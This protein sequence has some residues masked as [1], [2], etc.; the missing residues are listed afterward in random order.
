MAMQTVSH[1]R[2]PLQPSSSASSSSAAAAAAVASPSIPPRTSS[3][4]RYSTG[5]SVPAAGAPAPSN[6]T[7]GPST[8]HNAFTTQPPDAA[9]LL[10]RL[11]VS[12]PRVD[13]AR[14]QQREMG[15]TSVSSTGGSV[16][17]QSLATAGSPDAEA[18]AR[19]AGRAAADPHGYHAR[20]RET[21]FGQYVLGQTLGEGEFGKVK[22]GWR[23]ADAVQ[24]AIKLIR[25]ES[26]G[27]N[28]SRLPK[29]HREIMILKELSHPNIVRLHEMV[30][31]DRYIGIILE[32]ASGGELFDYILNHRYLKDGAARRLFAQLVSGVGY[33]HK[34]GIVHRDLKLENL[35]L[36]RNRNII[37]TDFGFA[38]T[39]DP[40]DDLSEEIEQNLGN[41][42]FVR[43]LRLDRPDAKGARRGDLMQ[44][45]CGSPCYAA[46]ELVVSDS[47]YT[48]RK[49]DVWSCGVILYAMLAGYL[50]FD[51]DPANPD[52]D[53]INLLYK[54]IV[55]TPLT[56]PEHITPHARDLLRRILVPDP[57]K[58]ADLFEVARHSWLAEY[59]HI[60]SH[61]T[62]GTTNVADIANTTVPAGEFV[63]LS[64]PL[65]QSSSDNPENPEPP[66]LTRSASVREPPKA[67]ATYS[68]ALGG[69][70][71]PG[72]SISPDD[73]SR[74]Q[75][76]AKRR[77]LQVEYVPPQSQTSRGTSQQ[78]QQNQ[79]QQQQQQQQ[80]Y[81]RK[82][83]ERDAYSN[84]PLP[85]EPAAAAAAAATPSQ[86]DAD[87]DRQRKSGDFARSISD[88]TGAF[89][90]TQ[91]QGAL[92]PLSRPVTGGSMASAAGANRFDNRVPP[93]RGSYGQPQ[94]PSSQQQQGPPQPMQ[95]PPPRPSTQQTSLE[96]RAAS[97]SPVPGPGK[98]HKRS[99]TVS[100]I[101]EKLFGRTSSLFGSGGST[102]AANS[103]SSSSS[104]PP[105]SA[106]TQAPSRSRPSKRYP[107]TSMKEPLY[108]SPGGVYPSG[109][110]APRASID[111][112]RSLSNPFHRKHD[113]DVSSPGGRPRRFSLLP[114]VLTRPFSSSHGHGSGNVSGS[115]SGGSGESIPVALATNPNASTNANVPAGADWRVGM[116]DSRP[117]LAGTTAE[118]G[119]PGPIEDS[120]RSS[121]FDPRLDGGG[122][123]R[124]P[125]PQQQQRVYHPHHLRTE[126]DFYYPNTHA[127]G[128]AANGVFSD[129][130]LL[131]SPTQATVPAT[132][133][134]D[135][136]TT[137]SA[138][139]MTL[140]PS[141]S[142]R[143]TG[144]VFRH[145]RRFDEAYEPELGT[146]VGA[147]AHGGSSGPA[148]R[149]M[150]FFRRRAKARVG[151]V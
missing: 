80:Q 54:Y 8:A 76:D 131:T 107:P 74:P 17:Q 99:T 123:L 2:D 68:P 13:I 71:H 84:K 82:D 5:A 86:A 70:T 75:R 145:N 1:P 55:S 124:Q 30:E 81:S 31:T 96:Y 27:S 64:G 79:H 139:A 111:S 37:I 97:S 38:N 23:R 151:D 66:L 147:A 14:E 94:Q 106:A 90:G 61:I 137:T 7:T 117:S 40:E 130:N 85:A 67:A 42:H 21:T 113:S 45:S 15:S 72:A 118:G 142:A 50:P 116:G 32:Y 134:P 140:P 12:D 88:L 26:L 52:G 87:A 16:T 143:P 110:A 104:K 92:P 112:R 114:P 83:K 127:T 53:N 10:S 69:L 121:L 120:D 135:P 95:Y 65:S 126:A 36:D 9:D 108:T 47:L 20:R 144:P 34:K 56:F 128:T 149:V 19:R 46:P 78:Q 51:D 129:S 24:V 77:T 35:L 6:G 150:D 122:Q 105:V 148:R 39:F 22:L 93:S 44:T 102:A 119:G 89:S 138:S 91:S 4:Q 41:R 57:R 59:A 33:L 133:A 98:G 18:A 49:V 25:R 132:A 43:S 29:I 73:P 62:S 146:G 103:G 115:G 63:S 58:R 109:T 3:T 136:T 48:A 28:P 60:V 125:H 11:V 101:G 100:S 141:S